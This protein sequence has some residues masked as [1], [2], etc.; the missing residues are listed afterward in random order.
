MLCQRAPESTIMLCQRAPPQPGNRPAR[1]IGSSRNLLSVI[2]NS[3]PLI[4]RFAAS[5]EPAAACRVDGWG[6][7]E[8]K[9]VDVALSRRPQGVQGREVR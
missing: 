8:G 2:F 7:R 3:V 4:A 1:R 5:G 9:R 6:E